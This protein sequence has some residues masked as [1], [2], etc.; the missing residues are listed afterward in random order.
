MRSFV[1]VAKATALE[2]LSEPLTLLVLLA[3]L[4][5]SVLAP[6]F[7]YHQFGEATRMARDSGFSA[8]F[9]CGTVVA[10][11][12]AIR[13]FRREIESG[14]IQ[15]AL[16]HP[17]S[18]GAFFLAK[19]LGAFA[20]YLLFAAT[21][22]CTSL[23]IVEGAKIGGAIA[24]RTG[25]MARLYGP[26]LAAGV[27]VMLVP[28][29]VGAALNRFL[30]FR[31]VL[32]AMATAFVVSLVAAGVCA[33][34]DKD[35]L[36]RHLPPA[37]L[38]AILAAMFLSAAAALAVRLRANA[39]AAGAGVLFALF[40]PFAG[41]YC[42]SDALANGGHVPWGYVGLAAL[43]AAPAALAALAV[44]MRFIGERDVS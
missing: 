22:F 11:F 4:A 5:L 35:L 41:N 42:M 3:A 2:V 16:A 7:H 13:T 32:S 30:R 36:P 10:V 24:A 31:F 25:D 15:M 23:D 8:L 1:S 44:G 14:T 33:A 20:A 38:L 39:A 12:G 9:V 40:L 21:V 17:V 27:A 28:L 37:A 34:F 18:R 26:C 19:A 29:V 43:A 6:T